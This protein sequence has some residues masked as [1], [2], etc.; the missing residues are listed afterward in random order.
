MHLKCLHGISLLELHCPLYFLCNLAVVFETSDYITLH[1]TGGSPLQRWQNSAGDQAVLT[2]RLL[3]PSCWWIRARFCWGTKGQK[4]GYCAIWV[5]RS[6]TVFKVRVRNA[7]KEID[8]CL[9]IVNI[10]I[11]CI[12]NLKNV[13]M[14]SIFLFW[15]PIK[16]EVAQQHHKLYLT[17]IES[18]VSMQTLGFITYHSLKDHQVL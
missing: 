8:S 13:L 15:T 10:A 16:V 17:V 11:A 1:C 4:F 5:D 12:C 3:H 6:S 2:G 14:G 18:A 7:V 9:I